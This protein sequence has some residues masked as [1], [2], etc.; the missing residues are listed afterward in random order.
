MAVPF[1]LVFEALRLYLCYTPAFRATLLP[2]LLFVA[3]VACCMLILTF[4]VPVVYVSLILPLLYVAFLL[5]VAHLGLKW[6]LMD[7]EG[8]R[9]EDEE[10]E[11]DDAKTDNAQFPNH[12]VLDTESERGGGAPALP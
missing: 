8:P 5:K 1:Y 2:D 11:Q 4:N 6:R 7:S 10:Q 9:E 3:L 12:F